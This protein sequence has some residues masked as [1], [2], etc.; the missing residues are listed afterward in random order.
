VAFLSA[1]E[2]SQRVVGV[3]RPSMVFTKHALLPGE[4]VVQQALGFIEF[5]RVILIVGRQTGLGLQGRHVPRAMLRLHPFPGAFQHRLTRSNNAASS[6][7]EAR[8]KLS[9]SSGVAFSIASRKMSRSRFIRF[10]RALSRAG[11]DF[12]RGRTPAAESHV[13]QAT[14]MKMEKVVRH[15][16]PPLLFLEEL[17]HPSYES[18]IFQGVDVSDRGLVHGRCGT[19]YSGC[20]RIRRTR[21]FGIQSS[22]FRLCSTS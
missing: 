3:A 6:P 5:S 22:S 15:C 10:R 12:A 9:R 13:A 1:V 4:D 21:F 7:Q 19:V 2:K 20:D 16:T 11:R 8:T 17:F 14:G 18:G